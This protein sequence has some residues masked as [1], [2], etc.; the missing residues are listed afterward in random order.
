MSLMGEMFGYDSRDNDLL[1]TSRD[2]N[3]NC[4]VCGVSAYAH[5]PK[6][7]AECSQKLFQPEFVK[8]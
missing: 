1:G 2:E 3:N 4:P 8:K 6:M 7:E 5:T